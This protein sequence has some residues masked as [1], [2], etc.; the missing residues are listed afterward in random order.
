MQI[1][2][3]RI[4]IQN[5][6][7]SFALVMDLLCSGVPEPFKIFTSALGTDN[8]ESWEIKRLTIMQGY[9]PSFQLWPA[10]GDTR[11]LQRSSYQ[12][13][14]GSLAEH[15]APLVVSLKICLLT[16]TSPSTYSAADLH[17]ALPPSSNAPNR[18]HPPRPPS[19]LPS[20]AAVCYLRQAIYLF[21]LFS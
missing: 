1:M 16:N 11:G 9:R 19:S 3:I 21:L 17:P 13:S 20:A 18:L 7:R 15:S 10:G 8:F 6:S 14:G 12:V 2:I 4:I 5:P